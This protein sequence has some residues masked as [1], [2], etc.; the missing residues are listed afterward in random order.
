MRSQNKSKDETFSRD[1]FTHK[2]KTNNLSRES[3]FTRLI[4][5][6]RIGRVHKSREISLP[7]F[8]FYLVMVP[9]KRYDYKLPYWKSEQCQ[10]LR[11]STVV[12][13]CRREKR[14]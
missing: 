8:L 3:L 13:T 12:Q 7:P 5:Y 1:D 11:I 6:K 4:G 2:N 14:S 9:K 10:Y